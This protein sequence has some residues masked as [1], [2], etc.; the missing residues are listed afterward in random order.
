MI[1]IGIKY[2]SENKF[3]LSHHIMKERTGEKKIYPPP[4]SNDPILNHQRNNLLETR[5]KNPNLPTLR[6]NQTLP[7]H[8]TQETIP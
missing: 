6:N 1:F 3:S 4:F 2:F 7:S 8:A 5:K